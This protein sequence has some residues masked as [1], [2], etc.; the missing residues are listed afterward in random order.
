MFKSDTFF[1]FC[2]YGL[3]FVLCYDFS[4]CHRHLN[5]V[6]K[7]EQYCERNS[8]SYGTMGFCLVSIYKIEVFASSYLYKYNI[9]IPTYRQRSEMHKVIWNWLFKERRKNFMGKY[10]D[11]V[12]LLCTY[13][14]FMYIIAVDSSCDAIVW[15]TEMLSNC[16]FHWVIHM[17]WL[18]N[19]CLQ[20][21][22]CLTAHW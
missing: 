15:Y 4:Q 6:V 21:F 16:I 3:S 2:S 12:F 8:F 7:T 11:V 10:W 20:M 19:D 17:I 13:F 9:K 1:F 5:I 22:V 14:T 18:R